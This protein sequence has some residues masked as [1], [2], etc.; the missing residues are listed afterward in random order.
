VTLLKPIEL[1]YRGVNRLRRWLYRRGFL[2]S[3][4][5]HRPV[6]SIG[7]IAAGGTGK[8]PAVIAVTKFLQA[9]GLR[10]TVLTR[11]YGR[12]SDY[13]GPITSLDADKFGDE[14]V[15]IKR[16]TNSN[17]IVGTNRYENARNIDTDIFVLDDGFQHLQLHRDLDVVIDAPSR[18][19][20]E[21]R[22]ALK[23]ADIVIPRRL[24]RRVPHIDG[25]LFA[26]AGLADN[27][28]FFEGLNAIGTRGFPDHHRY[29]A[30]DI[31]ALKRDARGATLV[32]SEKD[33]VKIDD[34]AITAIPAE[35]MIDQAVLD[36]IADV[37]SAP[38]EKRRKRRR[39]KGALLTRV[40]YAA[41]RFVARRV[42]TMSEERVQRWGTRLG[43]LA[44]K[45]VRKR[46]RLAMKNLRRVFPGKDERERRRILDACWRHF[47]R[48]FLL[49]MQR[50]N[51]SLQAI[52]ERCLMEG[53]EHLT[54]A[55]ARGKGTLILS[56]HWGAW[57]LGGLALLSLVPKTLAVARPL[58]N[59]LLERD[60]QRMRERTGSEVVDRRKAARALLKTLS[61]NGVVVLL[62]DQ[63]VQPR[64]GILSPFLGHPAW[65]TPAP[66]RMALRTGSTIVFA[67]CIPD[68]LRHR[69][70]FE[71][72]IR[73][74]E[75]AEKE[76]NVEALTNRINEVIGR[77]IVQ[78][79]E[80]WLWMH[81]RWKG[82]GEREVTNG[83]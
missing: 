44:S 73:V 5:L 47:G 72:P 20:R 4:K 81:D 9:R 55:M 52:A 63:A 28:Q 38:P 67:F 14:P 35:F 56:G 53:V 57:E 16:A 3:R 42:A 31:E 36:R 82:T 43:A 10:V 64:E 24:E 69:L 18:F 80:L 23:H 11:G 48:E 13:E 1:A 78:R 25:P 12:A 22:S 77:R 66:A 58:D 79:P 40:E 17:V 15:L 75:L 19:H 2:R 7:N 41:F 37:A 26:F 49:S 27:E 34:P 71:E 68:G 51:L 70:V 33:A 50:Q 8:T 83:V 65:T 45:V 61:G 74:D 29:T 46:D 60:L 21:G 62:P 76:R 32:T 54:A 59:E 39:R 6:I 30:A